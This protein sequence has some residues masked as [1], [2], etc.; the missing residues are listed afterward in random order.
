MTTAAQFQTKVTKAATNMDRFDGFV[1]G[2][3]NTIVNTDSGP[4]PS[5]QKLIADGLLVPGTG[6]DLTQTNI[7]NAITDK[8]AFRTNIQFNEAVDDR[9][10]ALLVPGSGISL[11]YDDTANTLTIANSGGAGLGDVVGPSSSI[12]GRLAL[13]DG[14]TGKLLKQAGVSVS[15][16]ATATHTHTASQITD[17]NEAVDDRV[18]ALLVPGSNITLSYNDASNTL[19]ISSTGGSSDTSVIRPEDYGAVGDGT[20]NDATALQNAINAAIAQSKTLYLN[21]KYRCNSNLSVSSN[22]LVIK[23]R[24][25][26]ESTI[27]FGSDAGI[28][29]TGG[30]PGDY[31]GYSFSLEDFKIRTVGSHPSAVIRASYT[32]N[33]LGRTQ[34]Q[35]SFRGIDISGASAND[36]F[37]KGIH[38]TNVQNVA[39]TECR[40][41]GGD[42]DFISS[43]ATFASSQGIIIDGD[44]NPTEIKMWDVRLYNLNDAI[45]IGGTTE[46]VYLNNIL[47]ISAQRGIVDVTGGEPLLTINNSHINTYRVGV[48]AV[49]R[50]QSH[51]SNCLIYA[52]GDETYTGLKLRCGVGPTMSWTLVGNVFFGFGATGS[53][54]AIDID[55][56]SAGSPGGNK[57]TIIESNHFENF[58]LAVKLGSYAS[59]VTVGPT[60]SYVNVTTLFTDAGPGNAIHVPLLRQSGVPSSLLFAT[61]PSITNVFC[62]ANFGP[63]ANN[64]LDLGYTGLRWKKGW[65][66]S[67]DSSGDVAGGS[68]TTTGQATSAID[69]TAKLEV[70]TSVTT[71]TA[72]AHILD[73]NG[74]SFVAT[75]DPNNP[76]RLRAGGQY[77]QITTA[78]I[79]GYTVLVMV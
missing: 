4:V 47:V 37:G 60:N 7:Q 46:G 53:K 9:V 29:I 48:D 35:V 78:V 63:D 73:G 67:I 13:F 20:T 19:T 23:G 3:E 31:T 43:P 18:A 77:R 56:I 74:F 68:L 28:V 61:D 36:H 51:I 62:G 14:T 5:I 72:V 15:S 17:L 66:N 1:N 75:G 45:T 52:F 32:A 34:S 41:D 16:F 24:N 22:D 26:K 57:N 58:G 54:T 11:T 70:Q 38:L 12:D 76:I 10:A 44:D 39:F 40:I 30:N 33:G 49:N 59:F 69:R 79:D 25:A 21:A 50:F 65:F 64:A 71:D 2:D 27:I 42:G 8:A 6:A 55:G